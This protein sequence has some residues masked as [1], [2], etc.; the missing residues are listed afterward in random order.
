MSTNPS[1]GLPSGAMPTMAHYRWAITSRALAAVLGG[2]A[3]SAL[4]CAAAGLSLLH[5]G[6]S[7]LDAVMTATML[8]FVVHA[9][10]AI[11]SFRARSASRVWVG[12]GIAAALLGGLAF[13]LGWKP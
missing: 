11:W 2:Y 1:L 7:R 13:T 6:T 3:V 4:F 10:S 12:I 5:T 8:A 9:L